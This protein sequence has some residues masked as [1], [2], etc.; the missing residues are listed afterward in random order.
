VDFWRWGLN[1]Y[2]VGR[3]DE[4]CSDIDKALAKDPK[5]GLAYALRAIIEVVQNERPQALAS[6]EKA[7]AL[8]PSAAAKIALSY[9]RQ[10]DFRLEAA[11][12]TLLSAVREHP[13]DSLAWARLAELW[14]M[15]AE[16]GKALDA[17]RKAETLAPDLARTQI[18]LGFAA[19]SDN[20]E[21]GS[22]TAFERA[23]S[24]SSDDPLAHLGLGLA[25]IKRGHLEEGRSEL[26][27]AVALDSSNALLRSY[28]GKAYYEEK[29]PPLEGKQYNI[30]KELDPADSTPYF[31]STIDK[32]TTN[33]PVQALHD[34]QKAIELNGNR[35]VYRSRLL[36]D[37]DLAAREASIA[38]IYTNLGFQQRALVEGWKS[39]N[40]DPSNFSAH[41]FLAD[42]Y[43]LRTAAP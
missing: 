42:S 13:E 33:R 34:L 22:K 16:R 11:R 2:D 19:L 5:A 7:V 38:R 18:V 3:V 9:A 25:K 41:R 28:L 21:A 8:T 12:E 35:A 31:Y 4:A 10:A 32:Q 23:I 20:R 39:V 43:L 1:N 24:L 6:A 30:A 14:L 15:F 17:A 37:S 29:R 36:L 26:E 27:A 40:A